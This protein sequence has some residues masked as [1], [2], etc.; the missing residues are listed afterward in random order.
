MSRNFRQSISTNLSN[1]GFSLKENVDFGE[2]KFDI[3]GHLS[4]LEFTKFGINDY[5][6]VV[7]EVND[8]SPEI[9]K[10]I[11]AQI[12]QYSKKHRNNF[13]PAGIFGGYWVFPIFICN[14]VSLSVSEWIKTSLPPKHW[15]SAEF[16]VVI[17]SSSGNS[18]Y[19]QGKVMWGAAYQAGFRQLAI[20]LI[21]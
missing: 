11:S 12:Y 13:L 2:Y 17:D 4:K 15:S 5:F 20:D 16:P 8:I 7:K 3:V 9:I 1:K 6:C 14:G 21:S 19:F 18:F 10:S